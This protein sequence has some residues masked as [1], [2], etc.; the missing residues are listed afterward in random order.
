MPDQSIKTHIPS[1]AQLIISVVGLVTTILSLLLL[2]VMARFSSSMESLAIPAN[3]QIHVL[4]WTGVLVSMVALP[5]LVLSIQRLSRK[6]M[7]TTRPRGLF[8]AASILCAVMIPSIYLVYKNPDILSSTPIMIILTVLAIAVP[9][10]WFVELGQHRLAAG[11]PQRQWG[12]VNF[13]VFVN[14][15]LVILVELIL[16]AVVF[17]VAGV[18]L[19]Q[20]LEFKSILMTLQTQLMLNPEDMTGILEQLKP[21]VEKPGVWVVGFFLVVLVIPLV[22]ELL[23]PLALWFFI[24]HEWSPSEGFTAGL[25][26]GASFALVESVT[27]LASVTQETWVATLIGRV[28]TG[29]LHTLT[30][31]LTGWALTS[32]WRDGKYKRV[33][34]TYLVSVSIHAAWNFFALLYGLGSNLEIFEN[35]SLSGLVS[36]S[37]WVL[38]SLFAVMLVIL[39]LMNQKIRK[40]AIPPSIPPSLPPLIPALPVE[41][42][43]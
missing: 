13:A 8:L 2:L 41:T 19:S 20:Q 43:G 1:I 17:I 36:V 25:I 30:A 11:S 10:W 40:S 35:S 15:P 5:S 14:L 6:P 23:K 42:I 16:L 24:K 28:G 39:F 31:G 18:W 32:S 26:C 22:E 37:P 27:S 29:L 33:G 4:I 7:K 34:I 12:L 3:Q 21:L 9:V 38:G